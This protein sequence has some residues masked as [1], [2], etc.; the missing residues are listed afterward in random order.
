MK[1]K[2][3]LKMSFKY[4]LILT[5]VV[6]IAGCKY[7]SEKDKRYPILYA[8]TLVNRKVAQKNIY[9]K[10]YLYIRQVYIKVF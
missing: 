2:M 8:K 7:A 1:K 6:W 3:H 5:I 10:L 4:F 9:K